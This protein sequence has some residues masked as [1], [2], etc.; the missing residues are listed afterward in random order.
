VVIAGADAS[1]RERLYVQDVG[2]G[3]PTPATGEGVTLAA[4]G[5]PVSPDGRRVVALGPDG[6]PA[7]YPLGGGE[8]TPVPGLGDDDLPMCWTPEGRELMIVRYGEDS[9]VVERVEVATGRKHRWG[10]PPRSLPAA[11]VGQSRILVTPDGRSYAYGHL[12]SLSGLYLSSPL[13]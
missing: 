11:H 3:A 10:G 12:R 2:G 4:L 8:P 9:P 13:E 5:R 6:V 7:V 1:D